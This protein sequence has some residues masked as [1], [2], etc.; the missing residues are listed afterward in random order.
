MTGD[1]HGLET[2]HMLSRYWNQNQNDMTGTWR[3]V[4]LMYRP[5]HGSK[6]KKYAAE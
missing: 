1:K 6:V 2:T 3:I 4:Q 5:F